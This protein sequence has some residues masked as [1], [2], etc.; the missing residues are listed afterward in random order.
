MILKSEIQEL[1]LILQTVTKNGR[2]LRAKTCFGTDF[3]KMPLWIKKPFSQIFFFFPLV[4]FNKHYDLYI[5]QSKIQIKSAVLSEGQCL[6]PVQLRREVTEK[7]GV[8][9]RERW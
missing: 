3:S 2:F 1:E 6:H 9:P 8:G 4:N 5:F 7:V